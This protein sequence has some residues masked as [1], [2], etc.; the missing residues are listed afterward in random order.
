V[1]A[2][3]ERS[4]RLMQSHLGRVPRTL[5][6][7][8]G[9]YYGP[10]L[11][12]T[13]DVGF[14]FALTLEA[15]PADAHRPLAIPRYYPSRDPKLGPIAEGLR[16]A[17]P[18]PTVRRVACLDSG[19][20]TDED[21]LGHTIESL[22]RL[23]ANTVVLAPAPTVRTDPAAF[24]AD[25]AALSFA[26]WQLR[27]RAGLA[28]FLRADAATTDVAAMQDLVRVAPYNGVLLDNAGD[29]AAFGPVRIAPYAWTIR[30]ARDALDPNDLDAVGRHALAL[31]RAAQALRPSLQ[32][33]LAAPIDP[34]PNDTRGAAGTAEFPA[35]AADW[36]L[37]STDSSN[38]GLPALAAA[39]AARGWLAPDIGPRLAL[40]VVA[41]IGARALRAAQTMGATAFATCPATLPATPG[42]AAAFS[43]ATF[44]RLP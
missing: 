40:P 3:L 44:P 27:T 26:A 25:R 7:P 6:W 2:D 1:R 13:R 16:F 36:L 5:V 18:A 11:A 38:T 8:F 28:I 23:G 14:S 34:A 30:A 17:D 33:A 9:R 37:V 12:A 32:L 21:T 24:G 31:W 19:P 39:L 15:E 22:R 42:F 41:N 20:L 10:A 35:S 4:R 43:A 29:L